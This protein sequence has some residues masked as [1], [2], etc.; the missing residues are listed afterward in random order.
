MSGSLAK[1]VGGRYVAI[2]GPATATRGAFFVWEAMSRISK[3]HIGPP[4]STTPVTP[5]TRYR[6]NVYGNL[7]LIH[8]ISFSYERHLRRSTISRR[9]DIPPESETCTCPSI[10][11]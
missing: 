7:C 6:S 9:G 4:Q 3:F 1:V 2:R 10:R 11:P 5:E 8:S